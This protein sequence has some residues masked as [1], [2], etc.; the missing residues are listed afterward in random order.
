MGAGFAGL[1]SDAG[2][3]PKGCQ[4]SASPNT[5][6]VASLHSLSLT[7]LRGTGCPSC[8]FVRFARCTRAERRG[9]DQVKNLGLPQDMLKALAQKNLETPLGKRCKSRSSSTDRSAPASQGIR[10]SDYCCQDVPLEEGRHMG[11]SILG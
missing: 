3:S 6:T 5:S 10:C 2:P 8:L 11:L 7:Y 1:P 4:N 9:G